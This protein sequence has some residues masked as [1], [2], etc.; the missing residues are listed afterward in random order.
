MEAFF[1]DQVENLPD[2][3]VNKIR[4]KKLLFLGFSPN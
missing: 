4:S 2:E 3:L 1:S